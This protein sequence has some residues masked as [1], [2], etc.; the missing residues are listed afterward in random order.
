MLCPHCTQCSA[1]SIHPKYCGFKYKTFISSVLP[2]PGIGTGLNLSSASR[3]DPKYRYLSFHFLHVAY[4]K[5]N[6]RVSSIYLY[7]T[8]LW[9]VLNYLILLYIRYLT[10]LSNRQNFGCFNNTIALSELF[11]VSSW[12]ERPRFCWPV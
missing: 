4:E 11:L 10:Y 2:S 9:R 12:S 8:S 7:T 6:I 3:F 5:E 1:W